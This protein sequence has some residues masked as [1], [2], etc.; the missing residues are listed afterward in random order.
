MKRKLE[1]NHVHLKPFTYCRV[2]VDSTLLSRPSCCTE[3]IVCGIDI[4]SNAQFKATSIGIA[5]FIVQNAKNG[6]LNECDKTLK[7]TPNTC[8]TA[9]SAKSRIRRGKVHEEHS[10]RAL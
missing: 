10:T 3:I 8:H 9:L 4:S 7:R 5:L 6:Y 2:R 1:R